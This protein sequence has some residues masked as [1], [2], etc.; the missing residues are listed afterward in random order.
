MAEGR[1]WQTLDECGKNDTVA[2]LSHGL[3]PK[4]QDAVVQSHKGEGAAGT[5]YNIY[6]HNHE[7]RH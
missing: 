3:H 2:W 4:R 7:A 6:L 5:I 1:Q